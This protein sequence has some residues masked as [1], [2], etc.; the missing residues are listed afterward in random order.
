MKCILMSKLI[1]Q[2]PNQCKYICANGLW[3]CLTS[4]QCT[5]SYWHVKIYFTYASSQSVSMSLT[6]SASMI[7]SCNSGSRRSRSSCTGAMAWSDEDWSYS[8]DDEMHHT[9]NYTV[10]VCCWFYVAFVTRLYKLW[11]WWPHVVLRDWTSFSGR[12]L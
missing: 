7:L 11:K 6:C 1:V 5:A 4:A 10:I 2:F 12:V 3:C 9:R 8:S